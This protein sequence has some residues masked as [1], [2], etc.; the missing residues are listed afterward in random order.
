MIELQRGRESERKWKG[1]T[2]RERE[3]EGRMREEKNGGRGG[4]FLGSDPFHQNA[5]HFSFK[6]EKQRH[7]NI[8][9]VKEKKKLN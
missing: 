3:G 1:V 4:G 7:F 8:E 9:R 5:C 2:E 6:N